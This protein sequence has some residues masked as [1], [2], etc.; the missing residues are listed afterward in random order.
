MSHYA[1][2]NS[3]R[4]YS[5]TILTNTRFRRRPSRLI[6]QAECLASRGPLPG[7]TDFGKLSRAVETAVAHCDHR[8]TSR[9]I[10]RNT[11][12]CGPL[13]VRI[14][15]PVPTSGTGVLSRPV[16]PPVLGPAASGPA[17]SLM[18]MRGVMFMAFTRVNPLFV[19]YRFRSPASRGHCCDRSR[20]EQPQ[21]SSTSTA[22][23]EC[24]CGSARRYCTGETS[25]QQGVRS[26][27][28]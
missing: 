16:V 28:S 26:R 14:G 21:L 17:A 6:G 9:P 8:C 13:Q 18:G 10:T 22:E 11:R 7:A 3:E 2:D 1:Q 15:I 27:S 24:C 20:P 5:P 12:S 25:R 23:N 4:H 19:V